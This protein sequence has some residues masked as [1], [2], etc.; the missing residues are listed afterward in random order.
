MTTLANLSL[1]LASAWLLYRVRKERRDFQVEIARERLTTF[2]LGQAIGSMSNECEN[3]ET[4]CLVYLDLARSA[5]E[6]AQRAQNAAEAA[7]NTLGVGHGP[8]QN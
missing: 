5:A 6:R 3:S 8:G 2:N 4:A 1:T 7:K